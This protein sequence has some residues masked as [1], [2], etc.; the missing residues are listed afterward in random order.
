[1]NAL[2]KVKVSEKCLR[3]QSLLDLAKQCE[4]SDANGQTAKS[5]DLPDALACYIRIHTSS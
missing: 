3:L 2:N 4:S 5:A 1:M